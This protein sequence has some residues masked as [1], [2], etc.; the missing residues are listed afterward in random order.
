MKKSLLVSVALAMTATTVCAQPYAEAIPFGVRPAGKRLAAAVSSQAMKPAKIKAEKKSNYYLRP[1]GALYLGRDC[2][3]G[4][5]Y[6]PVEI[7][8]PGAYDATFRKVSTDGADTYWHLNAWNWDGDLTSVDCTGATTDSY[9][10][11]ANGN[12]HL[13][14][15]F[16]GGNSLPTLVWAT[17]SFAIGQENPYFGETGTNAFLK[18]YPQIFSGVDRAN[19]R[20]LP[21]TYTTPHMGEVFFGALNNTFLYGGGTFA[22]DGKTY[23]ATGVYQYF[24]KPMAPLTVENIYFTAIS[25]GYMPIPQGKELKLQ[26][27]DV[28]EQGGVRIPGENILYELTAT[29]SDVKGIGAVDYDESTSYNASTIIFKNKDANGKTLNMLID[30]PFYVVLYGLD[31]DGIDCG[32]SGCEIPYYYDN[33]DPAYGIWNDEAGQPEFFSLY[34]GTALNVGFT[35]KYDYCNPM[36]YGPDENYG[37][38]KVSDDGNTAET[39]AKGDTFGG[40]MMKLNSDWYDADGNANYTINGLPDWV[41]SYEVD[42]ESYAAYEVTVINFKCQPLPADVSGRQCELTV[43]GYGCQ[44]TYPIVLLQG[45]AVYNGIH[46]V[47]ADAAKDGKTYNLAGQGVSDNA[48]GIVIRNGKKLVVR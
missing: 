32:L 30:Q 4:E 19:R 14:A 36:Y 7:C 20:M 6:G 37:I 35:A 43:S 2:E 34:S 15:T 16:D 48:K 31:Q 1:E 26:I 23:T 29:S 47:T 24:D 12:F 44:S 10:T 13:K 18:Y 40:V 5:M 45:D 21:L 8:L 46:G 17:D 9:Y 28:L 38:I 27:H 11:D 42:T 39:V 33:F 3:K 22:Q 25:K 41:K